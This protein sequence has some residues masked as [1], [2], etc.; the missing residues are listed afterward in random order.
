MEVRIYWDDKQFDS[1]YCDQVVFKNDYN[2]LVLY[3]GSD[4]RSIYLPDVY[5]V[6][7]K[8]DN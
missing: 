4:Q 5:K 6:V 8:G 2:F 7:V 3:I 1:Q